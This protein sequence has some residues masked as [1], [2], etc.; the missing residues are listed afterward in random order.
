[1]R[2][3]PGEWENGRGSEKSAGTVSTLGTQQ[4]IDVLR[5]M[6]FELRFKRHA[7]YHLVICTCCTRKMFVV[8]IGHLFVKHAQIELFICC[9]TYSLSFFPLSIVV[10][11]YFF[12][13]ILYVS[14]TEWMLISSWM[15][16]L[17]D[18]WWFGCRCDCGR[19]SSL[20][21]FVFKNFFN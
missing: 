21:G 7:S 11:Q 3:T 16:V 6:N 19:A 2:P 4:P 15:L 17:L 14:A 1:M 5:S 10:K 9:M 8:Y 18:C 12:F 20:N 13:S